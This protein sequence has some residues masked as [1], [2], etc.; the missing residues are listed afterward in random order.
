[1][2]SFGQWGNDGES[3]SVLWMRQV[4]QLYESE[5]SHASC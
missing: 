1:M 2:K 5:V 3:S 4:C